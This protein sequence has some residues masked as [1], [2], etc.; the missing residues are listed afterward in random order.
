MIWFLLLD[1]QR[2]ALGFVQRKALSKPQ[3]FVFFLAR[4]AGEE[5]NAMVHVSK[6]S[7]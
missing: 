6:Q 7:G 1:R 3:L 2:T 5:K 4:S